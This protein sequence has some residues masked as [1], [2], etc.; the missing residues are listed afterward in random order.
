MKLS[1]RIENAICIVH[2]RDDITWQNAEDFRF[3]VQ[4]LTEDHHPQA[5]IVNLEEVRKIDS[6]GIGVL[7]SLYKSSHKRDI[8]WMLCQLSNDVAEVL[9]SIGLDKTF[10]FYETE[11]DALA[12]LQEA[13]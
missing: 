6:S 1:H 10:T 8:R 3:Y 13:L 2:V 12:E 7:Y 9:L 11:E 4:L 5:I